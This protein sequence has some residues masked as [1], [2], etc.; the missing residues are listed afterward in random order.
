MTALATALVGGGTASALGAA[1]ESS[2]PGLAGRTQAPASFNNS[3]ELCRAAR[4]WLD[5]PAGATA[6]Y[7]A[8]SDWEASLVAS[9]ADLFSGARSFD[10]DLATPSTVPR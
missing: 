6:L 10:A 3:A 1:G 8:I 4:E 7:G 2:G 5:D 9:M